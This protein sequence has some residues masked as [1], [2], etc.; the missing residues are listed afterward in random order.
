[1]KE[2]TKAYMAGLIDAE[3]CYSLSRHVNKLGY[4]MFDPEIRFT[5]TH[6][7]TARWAV[8]N[9]GGAYRTNVWSTG[10]K[11]YY[12]WK[13][14]ND[15]GASDFLDLI[16]PF[17]WMKKAE[18]EILREYFD[19]KGSMNKAKRELLYQR[20]S[21]LK[22]RESVTTNTPNFSID[23]KTTHAYM[24]GIFDG[25]GSAYIIK[26]FQQFHRSF[27]Y[28]AVASVANTNTSLTEQLVRLYGGKT[29]PKAL[30]NGGRLPM[31]EWEVSRNAEKEQFLLSVLP[32][33]TIKKEQAKA[34][35]EFTRLN[36]KV[37]PNKRSELHLLVS[38]LNG[39]KIES[40]L[41]SDTQSAP[42]V[43]A[44]A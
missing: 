36:G 2:T 10:W 37:N 12:Q 35:L 3:G 15:R 42:L 33:L 30:R 39:K 43:T 26:Y 7:P 21:E 4:V 5:T 27:A 1:M 9:F 16:T 34:V 13:I 14:G 32:Y 18:A 8:S 31:F 11:T 44:T 17:I 24:A 41:R 40:V 19:L 28:R 22:S 20:M 25:E 38:S 6:L 23:D 29:R